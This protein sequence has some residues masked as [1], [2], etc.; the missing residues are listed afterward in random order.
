MQNASVTA[1]HQAQTADWDASVGCCIFVS[2]ILLGHQWLLC[3]KGLQ[4]PDSPREKFG[5]SDWNAELQL[6]CSATGGGVLQT[7]ETLEIKQDVPPTNLVV[8]II[9]SIKL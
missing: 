2:Q 8:A 1:S 7:F 6:P 3:Q 4:G 5:A 9:H